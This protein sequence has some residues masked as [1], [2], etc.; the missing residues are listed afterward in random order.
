LAFVDA[1]ESPADLRPWLAA[2]AL[3]LGV[4]AC[5]GLSWIGYARIDL[6]H[7]A[8][9][10]ACASRDY[11][12]HWQDPVKYPEPFRYDFMGNPSTVVLVS[13]WLEDGPTLEFSRTL[14]WGC[15]A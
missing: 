3:S 1:H 15:P 11:H 4:V 8:F 7:M 5:L 14:P 13:L 6:L 10:P 9:I 12:L 2:L